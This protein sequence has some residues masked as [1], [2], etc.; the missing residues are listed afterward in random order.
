MTLYDLIRYAAAGIA[1]I[2]DGDNH[3][4]ASMITE[5]ISFRTLYDDAIGED[6]DDLTIGIKPYSDGSC[7][8]EF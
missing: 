8:E 3:T 2:H 5:L 1:V 6:L 4:K 7:P